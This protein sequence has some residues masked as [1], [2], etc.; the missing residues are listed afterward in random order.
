M[1]RTAPKDSDRMN[2]RIKADAK[3]R[4][5]RAAALRHTDLTSFV[6]Q[7]A[8]LAADAVITEAEAIKLSERDFTR[9]LELLDNP[10]KA[11][12]RLIAAA[13]ALP[14]TL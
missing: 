4:L 8:L 2:L 3:A 9:V 10:P 5:M 11:N 13:A 7:S 14:K 12:A 1:A 6:T